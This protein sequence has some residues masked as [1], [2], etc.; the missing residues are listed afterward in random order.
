[1]AASLVIGGNGFLGSHV[2][3]ALAAAGDTVT[4]FDRFS[5]RPMYTAPDVRSVVGDFESHAD[6]RVALE[7]QQKLFHFLSTTTPVTAENDPSMDVRTNLSASVE[8]FELAVQAGVQ[9]VFFASTGG[10]IYGDQ[11]GHLI[12]E[13]VVPQP[14][15][16][17]AIG[18]LA[19]EGYLRYFRRKHGLQS[20]SFR[21]S[22]PYGP[23]QH[24]QK[25][26]GV[27]PIFLQ[28]IAEGQ[29]VIVF[30]DGSMVRDYLYVKDAA[31]MVALAAAGDPQHDVYNIGSGTGV[32]V[33]ELIA[34]AR[35]VT[36]RSV[37]VQQVEQPVTFVNRSVL[38]ASR[39]TREFDLAAS[40]SL[41]EG[42]E[43][44]W[45]ATVGNL[46]AGGQGATA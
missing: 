34:V 17:Y 41:R 11:A 9:R 12:N 37:R 40:V 36:G 16:P 1:M 42:M 6:L 33:N 7:G 18:K 46:T 29:P 5:S 26:Q 30:G 21:I 25:R 24:P 32:S 45:Q 44:T 43:R 20:V 13:M 22:N 23:R 10:A 38:D 39:F 8:L 2:V 14:V 19:I 35:E 15:S 28:R 3:D 31:R 4:V 27:I